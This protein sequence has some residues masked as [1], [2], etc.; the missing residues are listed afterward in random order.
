MLAGCLGM[1]VLA[2]AG[3]CGGGSGGPTAPPARPDAPSTA[4]NAAYAFLDGYT[5]PTGR[6]IRRDQG[7]DTVSEGQAYAMLAAAAVGDP[8]RFDRIWG[9]TKSNL[10][11]RDG[12][13]AFHWQN[14][15]VADP[16]PATDADLDAARALL[17]AGCRFGRK[18]LNAD[19]A[20]IGR[21]ILA[22]ETA[23]VGSRRL[24][25]AGPWARRGR[26]VVNPSYLDPTTLLGLGNA[27]GN[28]AFAQ[29]AADT[30]AAIAQVSGPLPPDWAV[31]GRGTLQAAG[32]PDGSGVPIYGFDAPR[33]L[34][35]LAVDPSPDGRHIAASA[36]GALRGPMRSASAIVPR[37]LDG[38]PAGEAEHPVALVG[39]AGSAAA[40]GD[41][42]TAARLLDAAAALQRRAPTYYGAAVVALGRL[43][44]QSNLLDPGCRS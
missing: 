32:G 8:R 41:R 4:K 23:R 37:H 11:R 34:L 2:A 39:A 28:N 10:K 25:V 14:G 19:A 36:W 38:S 44:L 40:A 24:L 26:V 17:V 16:M 29:V 21:A 1:L 27:T 30:R 20:R 5:D 13:L 22:R 9:W 35:R 12:L 3:G 6:V 43:M 18:D 7:G 33:T 15:R 31:A 42:R